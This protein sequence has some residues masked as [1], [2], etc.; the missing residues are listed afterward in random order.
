MPR[1]LV[2]TALTVALVACGESRQE[3]YMQ[4]MKL[5]GE[6]ERGPCKL[7]YDKEAGANLLSGDQ[8]QQCLHVQT[9]AMALYDRAA[10]LGLK[11]ADFV[12]TH[13]QARARIERLEG[14]LK[15]LRA[16]ERPD[17]EPP[18]PAA[19]KE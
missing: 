2:L 9:E 10:A 7:L 4:G 17:L 19:K 5:E 6:A 14:M 12:Q 15:T 18:A 16:L 1:A 13:T 3:I 11:D 8:V